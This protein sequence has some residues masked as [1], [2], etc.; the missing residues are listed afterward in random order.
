V[1]GENAWTGSNGCPE[2]EGDGREAAPSHT[3]R[4]EE[5]Q[6][7]CGN[8]FARKAPIHV[9]P[10]AN[11]LRNQNNIFVTVTWC[12]FFADRIFRCPSREWRDFPTKHS[13]HGKFAPIADGLNENA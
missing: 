3:L 11:Q 6:G 2:K 5:K 9:I 12:F 4:R 1:I 7:A 10:T 8:R 13:I